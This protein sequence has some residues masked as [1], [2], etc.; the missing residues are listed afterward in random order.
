MK[1]FSRFASRLF[2]QSSEIG[3]PTKFF[4]FCGEAAESSSCSANCFVSLLRISELLRD[5]CAVRGSP[6]EPLMMLFCP[7]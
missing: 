3:H 1:K 5:I 4:D 6:A 2:P 7:G